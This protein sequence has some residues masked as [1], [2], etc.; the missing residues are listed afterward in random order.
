MSNGSSIPPPA[1]AAGVLHQAKVRDP[2]FWLEVVGWTLIAFCCLQVLLFSFGRDQSIYAVVAD[3]IL[4]GKMPYRDVWDFKPPGIYVVYAL[5]QGLFGKSMLAPRL[6]EVAGLVGM[7]FA[8]RRLGE[9]FFGERRVGVAAG[10][11][12]AL[13]H[14]QLDFWHTAQPETFGGF[15]IAFSLVL[16][17]GDYGR[18]RQWIAWAA[19][20]A[21]FG[22]AFVLKPPLGGG[23]VVC[24]AYLARR[25]FRRTERVRAALW[26]VA[27][28]AGA[29]V[30]PVAACLSWFVLTGASGALYWTLFEF[31]PGYTKLGWGYFSAPEAYY[32]GLQ[33]AFFR[34]SALAAFGVIAAIAMRPMH[35]REREGLLLVLGIVAVNVAGI[36]MQ[37]KFFQYHYGATLPLI[38]FM[39]GLGLYKLW[40]R[41]LSGGAGGV[42]AFVSFIVIAVAMR[43]AVRDLDHTFWPRCAV[44]MQYLLG[45][46]GYKT[47]AAMD[48]EIYHVADFSLDSGRQAARKIRDLSPEDASVFVWGFEPVVYWLSERQPATRYIYNVPQRA[49]W[50]QARARTEL[51]QDLGRAAPTVIAVQRGDI[52]PKV[53][54]DNLDSARA[55]W[56]F[57]ELAA[58]MDRNYR[59]CCAVSGFDLY[60]RTSARPRAATASGSSM[61]R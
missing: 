60:E 53:T 47:R 25:E 50:E 26:P 59:R 37:H 7:V 9:T 38:A 34:F 48:R 20:G 28:V 23:V 56:E 22:C 49:K 41:C 13:L 3:G 54:G 17:T 35:S 8:F 4:A 16:A 44:R 2:D 24:A 32:Y 14:A 29:S 51:M 30:V 15:L 52:F 57:P 6:V 61:R 19:L 11:V 18:R 27:V 39:A 43:E 12:A 42:L 31:T 21:L 45:T 1:A 55:L 5:A 10:A 33:E 36:A 40:R 46:G 58:L